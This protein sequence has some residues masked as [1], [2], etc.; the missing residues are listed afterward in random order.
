[1][2]RLHLPIL[3]DHG[4]QPLADVL[5]VILHAI[6]AFELLLNAKA[7]LTNNLYIIL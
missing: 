2:D 1:L 3:P 5:N 7:L 6:N 4:M